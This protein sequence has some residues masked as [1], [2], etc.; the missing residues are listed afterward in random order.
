[1]S[2]LFGILTCIIKKE[3]EKPE[4]NEYVYKPF[5]ISLIPYVLGII[6][7]NFFMTIAAVSLVLYINNN[8]R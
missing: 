4:W 3:M 2:D 6:C 8:K 7:V 1:M 5:L